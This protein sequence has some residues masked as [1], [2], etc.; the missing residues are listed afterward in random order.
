MMIDI[1]SETDD[2]QIDREADGS[3]KHTDETDREA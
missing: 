3:A 2:R 1:E